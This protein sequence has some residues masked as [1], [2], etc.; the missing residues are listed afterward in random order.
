MSY[1]G[2]LDIEFPVGS[3]V[4]VIGFPDDRLHGLGA[5]EDVDA[6]GYWKMRREDVFGLILVLAFTSYDAS[7]ETTNRT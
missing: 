7:L 4:S 5:L 6:Q 3:L 2:E 1:V